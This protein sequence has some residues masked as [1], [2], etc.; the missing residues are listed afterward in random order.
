MAAYYWTHRRFVNKN[1]IICCAHFELFKFERNVSAAGVLLLTCVIVTKL[2][3]CLA[4]FGLVRD[5]V[6]I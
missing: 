2:V 6:S 4:L 3:P 1:S 5:N